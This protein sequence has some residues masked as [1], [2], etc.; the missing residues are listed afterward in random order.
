MSTGQD[1]ILAAIRDA[2]APELSHGRRVVVGL[3]GGLDSVLLLQALSRLRVEM[4]FELS[5]IHVHHGLSPNADEWAVFCD[6][7]CDTL[8][9]PCTVARIQLPVATGKGVERVAREHRYAAFA[10]VDADVLCLAH[11]QNDRAETLLLNLFRGAGATGLAGLPGARYLGTKR[12]LRPLLGL[13]RSELQAWASEHRLR[14]IED[15]SNQDLRY[16]RNAIRHKVIPA[17]TTVFPG[18]V[19][20]LARTAA[21]MQEQMQLLDRLAESDGAA[22]RDA[23]GYLSVTRLQQLPESARRN[24]L[25]YAFGK[26]AIQIPSARRLTALSDQLG[27]ASADSEVFV[28]MGAVGVHLWR[29]HVWLDTAMDLPLPA[30]GALSPGDVPW[31]DGVLTIRPLLATAANLQVRPLGHGQRFWPLGR[32]RDAVTELL[33]A[34]GVPPWVRSRLPGVWSGDELIWVAILGASASPETLPAMAAMLTWA[35]HPARRLS[36]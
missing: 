20:V 34:Q 29:D 19:D 24:V 4:G 9:V 31:P 18:V 36:A 25:R 10:A 21:Q 12:L 15:E 33:R 27:S 3:S 14:W 23:S 28:R 17:V 35:P 13:P 6:T 2:L 1:K 30:T 8:D 7:L 22:C 11:H 26:E 16:R 5:A 32:C